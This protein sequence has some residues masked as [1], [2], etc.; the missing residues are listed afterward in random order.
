M[1]ARSPLLARLQYAVLV[2]CAVTLVAVALLAGLLAPRVIRGGAGAQLAEMT[3]LLLPTAAEHIARHDGAELERWA[4]E[5]VRGTNLRLTII[6]GRGTVLADSARTPD[7][8]ERMENPLER[9]EVRAA[10]DRGFGIDS[11]RSGT[12]GVDYV[13]AAQTVTLAQGELAVVR[14]AQPIAHLDDLHSQLWR[15]LLLAAV[16]GVVSAAAVF[17]WLR[18]RLLAPLAAAADGAHRMAG[19]DLDHRLALSSE[20]EAARLAAA[21][22][23]LGERVAEQ[24]R[25]AEAERDHL[26]EVLASMSEGVLVTGPDRRARL[27]NAA[28]RDLFALPAEPAGRTPLEITRQPI[29]DEL[30]RETALHG[31]AGSGS[32]DLDA[33]ERRT[34]ALTSAPLSRDGGVVVVARDVSPFSRLAE[35]RRDFV[36]NVSHELK[37]P[38]AAIRGYAE[39]LREGA[40]EDPP[41]GRRFVERILAQCA[42]LEA[43]LG[44]LLT[45]SRLESVEQTPAYEPVDL[46]AL[47]R[48]ALEVAAAAAGQRRVTLET[49]GAAG[50][51]MGDP[52]GLERLLLNLLDNA[53][54]YNREGGRVTL[55]LAALD[56]QASIEVEDTGI[57]IAPDALPRIF[58]RFYRVD[59]GRGRDQGG[60][61]L[62]L[63]IVKH[64]AQTHGGRVEVES[65]LERGTRFR[66]ILP[67]RPAR[68]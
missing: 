18:R 57:G 34:I 66:V 52:D 33:P 48:R 1:P 32:V 7:E 5:L 3:R 62:G 68:I 44:D 47:A 49:E 35:V 65:E 40:L 2:P 9:P 45:L 20:P 15:S 43:L 56:G 12:T 6:D 37:T 38:L 53:I 11:R 36:A 28:F 63:A 14:L 8:L 55:R 51:V 10:L 39:T 41:A 58:E 60:T 59:K 54:K 26:R 4:S 30:V 22:N 16:A 13:Y 17:L 19:G 24:V 29:L 27:A 31:R 64:V 46:D 67:R 25:A 50:S 61:G 42:R 23:R 21:I